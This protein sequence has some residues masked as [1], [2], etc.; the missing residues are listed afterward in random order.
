MSH[1][2][3]FYILLLNHKDYSAF[4]LFQDRLVWYYRGIWSRTEDQPTQCLVSHC[5]RWC[6]SGSHPQN[7]VLSTDQLIIVIVIFSNNRLFMDVLVSPQVGTCQSKLSVSNPPDRPAFTQ[8]CLLCHCR[9]PTRLHGHPQTDRH[10][11]YK[12]PERRVSLLSVLS[13]FIM[14][15]KEF[16]FTTVVEN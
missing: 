13:H 1:Q 3:E 5:Q 16:Y 12:S 4:L 8:C 11:I 14:M 10:P 2:K 6:P 9:T 7:Q 15:H